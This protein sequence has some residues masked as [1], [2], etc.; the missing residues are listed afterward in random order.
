MATLEDDPA[1][2]AS[3]LREASVRRAVLVPCML[4]AGHHASVQIWGSAPTT[5]ASMLAARGIETTCPHA[6]LGGVPAVRQLY[7]DKVASHEKSLRSVAAM[8]DVR[9]RA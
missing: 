9:K 2:T 5:W 1:R 6:G 3:A 7:V 4:V 8:A